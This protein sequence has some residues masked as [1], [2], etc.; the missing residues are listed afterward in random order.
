[1][2]TL[3]QAKSTKLTHTQK[4]NKTYI[5]KHHSNINFRLVSLSSIALVKMAYKARYIC[6]H[7]KKKEK[8]KEKTISMIY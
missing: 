3:S 1:M 6:W 7:I 5:H 4:C 2:Q 8:R